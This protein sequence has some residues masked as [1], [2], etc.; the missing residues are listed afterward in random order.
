MR[1]RYAQYIFRSS[2]QR[3][4]LV[5]R[6]A[7]IFVPPG[8]AIRLLYHHHTTTGTGSTQRCAATPGYFAEMGAASK[9]N[10]RETPGAAECTS[11]RGTTSY[12]KTVKTLPSHIHIRHQTPGPQSSRVRVK[13]SR[14][15]AT[16]EESI[17][18]GSAALVVS[19]LKTTQLL[20]YSKPTGPQRKTGNP[21]TTK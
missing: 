18:S 12:Q 21:N 9:Q 16:A 3:H 15:T 20:V 14:V 8:P 6:G 2:K 10:D 17:G 4:V 11:T 13:E 19:G 1:K 5:G 7:E